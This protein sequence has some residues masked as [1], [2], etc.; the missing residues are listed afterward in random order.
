MFKED[1]TAVT[2]DIAI[3]AKE[4]YEEMKQG[5]QSDDSSMKV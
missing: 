4:A 3:N 2:S 5:I 1:D